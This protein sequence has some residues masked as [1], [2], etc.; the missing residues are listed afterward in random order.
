MPPAAGSAP[1]P[2]ASKL[3]ALGLG[4]S[5]LQDINLVNLVTEDPTLRNQN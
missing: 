3:V 5:D 1:A 4:L 2:S